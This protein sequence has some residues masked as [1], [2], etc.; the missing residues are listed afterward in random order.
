[1][2][3][4]PN[5]YPAGLFADPTGSVTPF[6]CWIKDYPLPWNSQKASSILNYEDL[7]AKFRSHFSQQKRFMKTHLAVHKIEHREGESV[8]AFAT[9]NLGEHL[10]TDLPSTYKGLMEKTYIWT[11]ARE[12][13]TNRALNDRRDNFKSQIMVVDPL[14]ERYKKEKEKMSD[15]QLGEWKEERK[16]AKPVEAHVLMIS[17]KSCNPR[18]RYAE[19]DYNKMGEITFPPVTKDKSSSDPVIIKAYVSGRQV[20][21]VYMDSGSSYELIH[22]HYFLKLKPYIRSIRVDSKTPLVGFFREYSWPLGSN[23][24]HNLL[25][26]RTTMKQMGIAVSTIL[27]DIKF[28]TPNGMGTLLSK[29]SS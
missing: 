4:C 19:E 5:P 3:V 1:M 28:H 2:P 21:R 11:E 15:T 16:K 17:R 26:G 25:L 22:E 7:R 9:R 8:I 24:P 6:V 13:A 29:N 18:K 23:S 27:E 14:G 20:N 10:S 12:V